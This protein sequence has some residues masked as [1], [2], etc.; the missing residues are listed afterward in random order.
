LKSSIT[1]RRTISAQ[2]PSAFQLKEIYKG[3]AT[4]LRKLNICVNLKTTIP[5]KIDKI[6]THKKKTFSIGFLLT[7]R[8]P[9][10]AAKPDK[11][12]CQ[13]AAPLQSSFISTCKLVTRKGLENVEVC[14]PDQIPTF[15]FFSFEKRA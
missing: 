10:V 14:I 3:A 5:Q 12:N 9:H 15:F 1:Y 13:N 6:C 8:V 2:L 7:A 11:S 4:L